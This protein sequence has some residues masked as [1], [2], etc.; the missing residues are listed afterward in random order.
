MI[1]VYGNAEFNNVGYFGLDQFSAEAG[2]CS[3]H[4]VDCD[5]EIN[6][7]KYTNDNSL[8]LKWKRSTPS[9]TPEGGMP[10]ISYDHT[11]G[12]PQ[13]KSAKVRYRW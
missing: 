2:T 10:P 9:D 5:A 8:P 6:L 4:L 3:G 11:T 1:E 7:C 12:S 13:G